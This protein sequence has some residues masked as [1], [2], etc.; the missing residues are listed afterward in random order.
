[1]TDKTLLY[2][3]RLIWR[4]NPPGP[5][6]ESVAL[7]T[8]LV[9]FIPI[10]Y[11][12]VRGIQGGPERWITLLDTRIPYLLW[13]TLSLTAV[14]TFGALAIGVGAAWLVNRSDLPGRKLWEWLLALPL[15]IPP[16]VGAVSISL[17]SVPGGWCAA[18]RAI[19][20]SISI[21]SAGWPC[22]SPSLPTLMFTWWS[23]PP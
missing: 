13:N 7:A 9:M 11:V 16:Y 20:C 19:S 15:V 8:A 10:L 17:F 18:C 5:A 22:C 1:M 6:L 3:R 4:G 12:I 14:V 21:L 23:G 2:S